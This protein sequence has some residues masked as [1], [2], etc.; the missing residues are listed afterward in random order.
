MDLPELT[1]DQQQQLL[2]FTVAFLKAHPWAIWVIGFLLFLGGVAFV[3][4]VASDRID[5]E[6]LTSVRGKAA[7][8]IARRFGFLFKGLLVDLK[9]LFTGKAA[10]G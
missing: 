2:Q 4:G 8:R 1:P 6:K 5:P 7:Y 3:A 9:E 10:E